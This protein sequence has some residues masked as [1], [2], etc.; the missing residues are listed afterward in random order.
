[1]PKKLVCFTRSSPDIHRLPGVYC[2]GVAGYTT[3]DHSKLIKKMIHEDVRIM[4][5][6]CNVI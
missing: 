6:T 3:D 5:H 4:I 2:S 1:M